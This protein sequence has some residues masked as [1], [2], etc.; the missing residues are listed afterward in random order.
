MANMQLF[1]ISEIWW[2][3]ILRKNY[4]PIN[5]Y[6]TKNIEQKYKYIQ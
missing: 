4:E 2:N 5:G 1:G 6:Y 3:C